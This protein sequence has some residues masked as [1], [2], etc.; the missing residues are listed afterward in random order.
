MGGGSVLRVIRHCRHCVYAHPR[1]RSPA[2]SPIHSPCPAAAVVGM[3]GLIPACS[4]PVHSPLPCCCYCCVGVA[5]T[6]VAAATAMHTPS[7]FSFAHWHRCSHCHCCSCC[8]CVCT[9][10]PSSICVRSVLVFSSVCGITN[11]CKT[12][13]SFKHCI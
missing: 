10:W 8:C 11:T 3:P 1:S 5:V 2:G 7:L 13:I 12:K 9:H 4:S 6:V